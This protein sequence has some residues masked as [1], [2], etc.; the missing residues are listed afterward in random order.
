MTTILVT[1][2]RDFQ[3]NIVPYLDAL[4]TLVP[5]DSPITLIHGGSGN[6][7]WAAN[8]DAIRRGWTVLPYYAQ[9]KKFGKKAGPI[10]NTQLVAQHPHLALA[11]LSP[12][13]KGTLDCIKQ[14]ARSTMEEDSNFYVLL[15]VELDQ[16]T[17]RWL[18]VTQLQEEFGS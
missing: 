6:T 17:S 3:G 15:L 14:L 9:W 12:N 7:D 13:S 5:S 8:T 1:G 10:R 4:N 2:Y 11:I 18:N 16:G